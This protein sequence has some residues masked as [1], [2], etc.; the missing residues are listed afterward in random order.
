[1]SDEV[2]HAVNRIERFQLLRE[3]H[4]MRVLSKEKRQ[5][6]SGRLVLRPQTN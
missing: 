3:R 1:M 5:A 4:Q 2:M 6:A